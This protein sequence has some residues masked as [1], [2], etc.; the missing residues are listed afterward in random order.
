MARIERASKYDGVG[1]G[2]ANSEGQSKQTAPSKIRHCDQHI[3]CLS[4]IRT[5]MRPC[6]R[7]HL[8]PMECKHVLKIMVPNSTLGNLFRQLR[9]SDR[10]EMEEISP[11]PC[12]LR[13][14][15]ST[16][17]ICA[18]IEEFIEFRSCCQ[19]HKTEQI[20]HFP[21]KYRE[22]FLMGKE[23]YLKHECDA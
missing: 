1:E 15:P 16:F 5:R 11:F 19:L 18:S 20:Y 12:I 3:I 9:L 2:K 13:P 8:V 22:Y 21:T 10:L 6:R 7:L 17:S 4:D 23:K 14:S